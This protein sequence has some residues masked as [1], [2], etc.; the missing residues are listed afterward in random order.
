V[1]AV[2]L[3]FHAFISQPCHVRDFSPIYED[4]RLHLKKLIATSDFSMHMRAEEQNNHHYHTN[5]E[6]LYKFYRAS[7]YHCRL[8]YSTSSSRLVNTKAKA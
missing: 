7:V 4:G 8:F 1:I 2:V 3:V 5:N 6:A